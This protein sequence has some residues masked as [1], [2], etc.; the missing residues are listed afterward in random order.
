M[1]T[2]IADVTKPLK[3][4][5]NNAMLKTDAQEGMVYCNTLRRYDR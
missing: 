4:H 1:L 3:P 2:E 5:T